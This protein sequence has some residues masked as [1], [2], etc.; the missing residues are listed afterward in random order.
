MGTK[1]NY[2]G[3]WRRKAGL[4]QAQ[5][6]E[7]LAGMKGANAITTEASLSR[8]EKGEQNYTRDTINALAQI[9]GCETWELLAHDPDADND[10]IALAT[11]VPPT[12]G[13]AAAAMLRGLILAEQRQD[14]RGPPDDDEPLNPKKRR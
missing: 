8:I 9:Y 14:F 11:Q 7:L 4:T 12:Q 10:L 13:A 6:V 2:F 3:A 5:T 1:G